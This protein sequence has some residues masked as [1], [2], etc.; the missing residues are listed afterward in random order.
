MSK[1]TRRYWAGGLLI[2]ATLAIWSVSEPVIAQDLQG[3]TIRIINPFAAGG[4][5]DVVA[6]LIDVYVERRHEDERFIDTV[7]RL[8]VEPFKERVYASAH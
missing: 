5:T 3:K 2:C 6:R 7:R 8:G 1:A 4:T